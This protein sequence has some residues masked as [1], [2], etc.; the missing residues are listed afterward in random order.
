VQVSPD[1]ASV[2][3]DGAP[4]GVRGGAFEIAGALGSVHRVRVSKGD[5]EAA[6]D[7]FVTEKGAVPPRV[8]LA[9]PAPGK[10]R[11]PKREHSD[12]F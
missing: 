10:G 11:P 1:D 6:A 8:D 3:V 5:R 9:R 12:I 2:E 7:V 4:A